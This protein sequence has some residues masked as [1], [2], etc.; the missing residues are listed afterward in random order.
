LEEPDGIAGA[1][2]TLASVLRDRG[3]FAAAQPLYDECLA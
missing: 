1:L 2:I 3:D